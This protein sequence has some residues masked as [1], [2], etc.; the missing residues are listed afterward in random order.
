VALGVARRGGQWRGAGAAGQLGVGRKAVRAGD[1]ADQ[2][3]GGQRS[4]PLFGQQRRRRLGDQVGQLG[5][6][7]VDRPGE[8]ADAA[9]LVTR[10]PDAGQLSGTS[11]TAVDAVLPDR[12]D[13]CPRW[14][15]ELGPKVVQVPAQIVNQR[16]ALRDQSFAMIDQQP[17]IELTPGQ[18]RDRKRLECPP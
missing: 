15:L 8:L 1:L 13:Q 16:R 6:Q 7:R 2:L 12:G 10:D 4:A 18:L 9:K 5:L 3:G 11:E 17:N 14:D